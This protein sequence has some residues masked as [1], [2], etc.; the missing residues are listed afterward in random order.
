MQPHGL[1]SPWNSP[2]QNTRVG[3]LSLLQGI[4]P[5]QGLNLS[6]LHCRWILHQLSHQGSPR[7]L[8]WVA[9]PSSSGSSRPRNQTGVS[10][11]AGRVF[12]YWALRYWWQ[13]CHSNCRQ[14]CGCIFTLS[15]PIFLISIT[16]QG[17]FGLGKGTLNWEVQLLEHLL[18]ILHPSNKGPGWPREQWEQNSESTLIITVSMYW[19]SL[20]AQQWRT[21]LQCR[22][23]RRQRVRSLGW[24]D[25]PG[26]GNGNPLQYSCLGNPMDRGDWWATVYRVAKS[27][28]QL[29]WLSMHTCINMYWMYKK[30]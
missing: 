22:S 3:R 8:E 5:T 10:C 30:C 19:A 15:F 23:C 20:V 9:Y 28:M 16:C 1:Y 13:F 24:E 7:I 6:L 12:T 26:E 4:F 17:N 18:L 27:W 14:W 21:H 25:S 2:G 11:I 29:Q